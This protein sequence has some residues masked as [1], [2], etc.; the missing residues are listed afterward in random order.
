MTSAGVL[1]T[2]ALCAIIATSSLHTAHKMDRYSNHWKRFF[3]VSAGGLSLWALAQ[4]FAI[5]DSSGANA[6][7]VGLAVIISIGL[8]AMARHHEA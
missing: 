2:A 7:H 8:A 6:G 3:A 4:C 1:F 5:W